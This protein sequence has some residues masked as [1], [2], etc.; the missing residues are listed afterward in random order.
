ML[1]NGSLTGHYQQLPRRLR[2]FSNATFANFQPERDSPSLWSLRFL[3]SQRVLFLWVQIP[4]YPRSFTKYELMYASQNPQNTDDSS[5]VTASSSSG[6]YSTSAGSGAIPGGITGS[7]SM[8]NS[9]S[10]FMPTSTSSSSHEGAED[11]GHGHGHHHKGCRKKGHDL[12]QSQSGS[13]G[14]SSMG[15]GG[16]IGSYG[17]MSMSTGPSASSLAGSVGLSGGYPTASASAGEYGSDNPDDDMCKGDEY[18]GGSGTSEPIGSATSQPV[19]VTGSL[20]T[21]AASAS[22]LASSGA[23]PS[24]SSYP[25]NSQSSGSST[26]SGAGTQSSESY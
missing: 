22:G 23:S 14:S 24:G 25:S 21:G 17:G 13:Y 6:S 26:T 19:P 15:A 20:S 12:H 2:L 5:A 3:P 4:P 18:G 9:A 7:G 8:T 10:A 11:G 1:T 16:S